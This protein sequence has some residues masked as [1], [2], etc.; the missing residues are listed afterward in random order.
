MNASYRSVVWGVIPLGAL[1]GGLLGELIGLR[2]TLAIAAVG[3][4]FAPIWVL[5]SPIPR[6]ERLPL[7]PDE[8]PA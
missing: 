6:M 5:L 2:A 7:R 8:T 4:L 1:V 3:L